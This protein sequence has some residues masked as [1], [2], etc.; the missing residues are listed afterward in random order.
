MIL[1]HP[2]FLAGNSISEGRTLLV[3]WSFTG[4]S[5]FAAFV[6]FGLVSLVFLALGF[7]DEGASESPAS[8]RTSDVVASTSDSSSGSGRLRL[9]AAAFLRGMFKEEVV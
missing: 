9:G 5:A 1:T 4:L 8:E 3:G 6:A 7:E 2:S